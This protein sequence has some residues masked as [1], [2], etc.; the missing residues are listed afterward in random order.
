MTFAIHV[1]SSKTLA[2]AACKCQNRTAGGLE[3]VKKTNQVAGAAGRRPTGRQA[4]ANPGHVIDDG[5]RNEAPGNIGRGHSGSCGDR[6][7]GADLHVA[8]A[9]PRRLARRRRKSDP[10]GDGLDFVADGRIDVSVFPG[11][12]VSFHGVRIKGSDA[13]APALSVDVLTANLRLIP[14]LMQHFQIDD[15]MMLHPHI[16]VKRAADGR[17]NWTPFVETIARNMNPGADTRSRSRKSKSRMANS[18][19]RIRPVRFP[20][21]SATSICRW[22]GPRFPARSQRQDSSTGAANASTAA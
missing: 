9:R 12:Y 1:Y 20:K 16:R 14:L 13:E 10:Y 5:L 11:S 7:V 2:V 6:P 4:S 15:V 18:A 8:A 21:T 3:S 22:R 19:M 17:S